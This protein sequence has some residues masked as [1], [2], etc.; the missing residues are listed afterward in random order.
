MTKKLINAEEAIAQ[1]L[2]KEAKFRHS[3]DDEPHG[4]ERYWE[5]RW[6]DEK[7]ENEKLRAVLKCVQKHY[8][9]MG[10]V[11]SVLKDDKL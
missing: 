7:A 5:G 2:V 11:L 4:A 9:T 8:A 6:R 1:G 3:F 10:D